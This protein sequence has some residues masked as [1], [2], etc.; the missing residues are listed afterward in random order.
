MSG[1]VRE[2]LLVL[3]SALLNWSEKT[4]RIRCSLK[5]RTESVMALIRYTQSMQPEDHY[6]ILQQAGTVYWYGDQRVR[7]RKAVYMQMTS[8]CIK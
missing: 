1:N 3:R 2:L 8:S 7:E 5:V 6:R 4:R